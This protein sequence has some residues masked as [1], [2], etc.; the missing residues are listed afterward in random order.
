MSRD[1][2]GAEAAEATPAQHDV[3]RAVLAAVVAEV[4]EPL[5]Y[6]RVDLVPGPDGH[7]LLAEVE[8]IDP[9]L[10]LGPAPAGWPG[11]S[12]GWFGQGAGAGRA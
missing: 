6:A 4:A 2:P 1:D 9:R 7:P 5:T 8:L 12:A 3:A 10:F 11:P